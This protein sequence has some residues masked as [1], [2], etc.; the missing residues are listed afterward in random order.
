MDLSWDC[1]TFT[2]TC[3]KHL[4]AHHQEALYIEAVNHYELKGE[5]ATWWFCYTDHSVYLYPRV[6]IL[7]SWTAVVLIR[8][9]YDGDW[10]LLLWTDTSLSVRRG[11]QKRH[12]IEGCVRYVSRTGRLKLFCLCPGKCLGT[13]VK[14]VVDCLLALSGL[15]CHPSIWNILAST[16]GIS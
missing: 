16:G 9:C 11:C 1:F 6:R 14:T 8:L 5:S 13:F 7:F 15:F 10:L 3:F 12:N 4:F 2:F